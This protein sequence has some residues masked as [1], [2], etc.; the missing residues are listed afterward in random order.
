MEDCDSTW[1]T[2]SEPELQEPGGEE[3]PA[4]EAMGAGG[5]G[6]EEGGSGS[7]TGSDPPAE[8]EQRQ[9]GPLPAASC[10]PEDAELR[11]EAVEGDEGERQQEEDEDEDEGDAREGGGREEADA[12]GMEQ[13][14]RDPANFSGGRRVEGRRPSFSRLPSAP[15]PP[16]ARVSRQTC[17]EAALCPGMCVSARQGMQR[18]AAG[19]G[20][21]LGVAVGVSARCMS[22]SS[23]WMDSIGFPAPSPPLPFAWCVTQES[24]VA[25]AQTQRIFSCHSAS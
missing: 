19:L 1:E 24:S 7:G 21:R 11:E 16:A 5:E 10:R 17:A 4:L 18:G 12:P 22:Q 25:A 6:C 3:G 8:D 14:T 2:D 23:V 13:V 15:W 20:A 9:G